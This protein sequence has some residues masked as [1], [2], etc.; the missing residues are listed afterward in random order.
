MN[1]THQVNYEKVFRSG[2]LAGRRYPCNY[3]RFCSK[4]DAQAFAAKCDG[5][6]VFTACDGSGWQYVT[7]SAIISELE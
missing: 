2:V 4:P 3:I 1:Y 5:K 6:Q 7:E